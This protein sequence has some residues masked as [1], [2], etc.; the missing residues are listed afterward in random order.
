MS[1]V[2]DFGAAGDG[3][4]D[5]TDAV[6]H[7]LAD[8]DGTLQFPPGRYKLTAP[9]LVDLAQTGPTAI[10]G[11]GGAATLVMAGPGPA[12]E[13]RGTHAG[14]AHPPSVRPGVW[15]RERFPTLD[16]LAIEGAHPA[17]DGVLCAGVIQPTF[18]GLHVRGVNTAL[19]FAGRCRNV[20]VDGCHFYD[21]ARY[22]LHFD[23]V[24]CHQILIAS[25]HVSYNRRAGIAVVGG[26]IRNLQ[27]AGNDV[28]YNNGERRSGRPDGDGPE[29]AAD[30]L[31]DARAG[32]IREGT[33]VGNTIQATASPGGANVRFLGGDGRNAGMWSVTG[34]LIGSQEV[35]VHLAGARGVTLTGNHLYSGHRRNLLAEGCRN[36]VVGSNCLGHNPDYGDAGL[37]TGVELSDCE[38]VTLSG[39]LI[40]DFP[41]GENTVR[42]ARRFPR[43]ATVE[44]TRCRRATLSG[45]QIVDPSPD[46]LRLTDCDAVTIAGLTVT[47][48]RTPPRM[49]AA[50]RWTGGTGSL[51]GATLTRGTEAAAVLPPGVARAAIQELPPTA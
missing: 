32:S 23:G 51:C 19:R 45:V 33:I 48:T 35:N 24:N 9:V 46:G 22:G 29:P 1:D 50:V 25:S 42:N 36:L 49:A 15:R 31:I 27:I 5:D 37:V 2:R 41:A 10:S 17:A 43:A 21:N 14:T 7:A 4:L 11:A 13:L 30:V 40:Q 28:E 3:E 6:R 34:N 12:L 20:L 38:D 8:G 18:T 47:D 39:T 26:E 44:L 16:A